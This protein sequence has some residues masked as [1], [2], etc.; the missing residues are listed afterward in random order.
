MS[1][2]R[3]TTKRAGATRPGPAILITLLLAGCMGSED[4]PGVTKFGFGKGMRPD[5]IAAPTD[6]E[7]AKA[8]D[9]AQVRSPIIDDL[10][11]RRSILP[12]SG[13]YADV[14]NAVLEAS[15]RSAEAELRVARLRSEAKS[16]NWL[17]SIG[18][19]VDLTSLSSLATSILVEQVIFDNGHKK[20]ERAFA[21]ADV[22]I[23][24]VG[25]SIDMNDRVAQGLALYIKAERAR[26]Q[27]TLSQSA[28]VRMAE[29]E[30]IMGER[31]NG[32]LSDRSEQ[33]VITQKA[34]EIQ[35][36]LSADLETVKL[37]IAELNAMSSRPLDRVSGLQ[38]L[39][40][41]GISP[42][43]LAVLK[44]RGEG[45]QLVAQAQMERAGHLPGLK[46][47]A[48]ISDGDLVSGLRLGADQ[49]LGLGTGATMKA[50]EATGDVVDR[51]AAEAA[52]DAN[53]RIVSLQS[54]HAALAARQAQGAGVLAQTEASLDMF[55]E[56]YKVGR[57]PLMEL[58]GMYETFSQMER[59][60]AALQYDMALLRLEIARERG[61][62]VDGTKL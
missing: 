53:R 49:M 46:A 29:Y 62:L 1:V 22:E 59:D 20:A 28:A 26:S 31:V 52:E 61:V 39:P 48:A 30:R 44:A 2:T 55:T 5:D 38:T 34:A 15:A 50:I 57:R 18:P 27:A 24:A 35:A 14:T 37:S 19:S 54:K 51:R 21:A 43:A 33:N 4:T 23:A 25:L 40:P 58:V 42:E 60:Q 6:T 17:P 47:T 36:T 9:Q 11:S 7:M 41:D 10:M 16:K 32:G 8:N 13:P 3:R 56:Q 12:T 45:A